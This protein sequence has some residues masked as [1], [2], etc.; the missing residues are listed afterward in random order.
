MRTVAVT[1]VATP[2]S[3]STL[4][5]FISATDWSWHCEITFA[6]TVMLRVSPAC[7]AAG[8][9]IAR[10][11]ARVDRHVLRWLAIRS[12][13]LLYMSATPDEGFGIA[14]VLRRRSGDSRSRTEKHLVHVGTN[15]C[16][17][18][19]ECPSS[20]IGRA[21]CRETCYHSDEDL[22]GGATTA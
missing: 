3:A 7:P 19:A 9:A 11:A 20:E 15:E 22:G 4:P 5:K 13:F 12:D 14:L 10:A 17:A 16:V 6:D 2:A 1:G 21:P 8:T 18:W